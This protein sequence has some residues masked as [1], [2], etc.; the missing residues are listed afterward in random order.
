MATSFDAARQI[1]ETRFFKT[2]TNNVSDRTISFPIFLEGRQITQPNNCGWGVLIIDD[3]NAIGQE[4]GS[5]GVKNSGAIRVK[6]FYPHG[7]GTRPIREMADEI[8]A[9]L[10]YTDGN[11]CTTNEG[12]LF[13]RA[14]S[15]RRVSDDEDGYL[16]YNLDFIYDYYT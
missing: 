10:G 9:F 6:L 15:L 3:A 12:T 14:G 4:F 1:I 2:G 8:N 5:I 7:E 11:T 13:I 16:S